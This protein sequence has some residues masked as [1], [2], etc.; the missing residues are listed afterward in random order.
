[1]STA[2][3]TLCVC[4]SLAAPV[5]PADALTATAL[6]CAV[7]LRVHASGDEDES[8]AYGPQTVHTFFVRTLERGA[9]HLPAL[10]TRPPLPSPC[11]PASHQ[12]RAPRDLY[13][14]MYSFSYPL[15]CKRDGVERRWTFLEYYGECVAAA[16]ALLALGLG[17]RDTL[18]ILGF[19]APHW[20]FAN[21]GAIFAGCAARYATT[22][23]RQNSD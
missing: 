9:A 2:H 22:G 20:F 21:I 10:G 11:G 16:R 4:L 6:E 5:A 19:N 3:W 7:R 14:Y 12:S 1:M 15:V 13:V 18:A 17:A 8:S 23:W